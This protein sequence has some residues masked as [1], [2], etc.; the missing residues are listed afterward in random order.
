MADEVRHLS[1]AEIEALHIAVMER[2]GS[3]PPPFRAG[4]EYAH[5]LELVAERTDS[6]EAATA[7]IE[8]WL[9]AHVR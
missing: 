2:M 8:D 7:R 4:G 3:H 5:Q 6:L 1:L 9:R